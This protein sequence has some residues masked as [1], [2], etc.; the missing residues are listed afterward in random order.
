MKGSTPEERFAAQELQAIMLGNGTSG[1]TVRSSKKKNEVSI[2]FPEGHHHFKDGDTVHLSDDI[3]VP[4][5]PNKINTDLKDL[6]K[7]SLVAT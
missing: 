3:E 1:R 2:F 6:L 7:Q 5:D 4:I